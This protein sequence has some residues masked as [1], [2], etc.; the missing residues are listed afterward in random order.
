MS[1]MSFLL[2][3]ILFLVFFIYFSGLNPQDMTLVYYPG[4]SVTYSVAMV[5]LGALLVGLALGYLVHLYGTLAHL[6]KHWKHGRAEKRRGRF[7][8]SIAR[9]WA[10]CFP[11]T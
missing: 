11:A 10:G 6:M 1:L 5:V 4:E 8:P 3:I 2:L 7:R 9:G